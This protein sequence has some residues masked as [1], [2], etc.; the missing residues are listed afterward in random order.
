M[1]DLAFVLVKRAELPTSR[2]VIA[3]GKQLGIALIDAGTS[4]VLAFEIAS[5]GR[6][7]AM[8]AT[9]PHPDAAQMPPA[10]TSPS[11]DEIA[12]ARAHIVV[13]VLGLEGTARVRDTRMAMLASTMIDGGNAV[14]AMLGHGV[15]FRQAK[16]FAQ[17]AALGVD[18]DLP[19]ELAI[20]ITA[21]RE[22]ATRMSFLTH[23]LPRYGREDF[24]VT[25]PIEGE[26]AL[27][28]VLGLVRWMWTDPDKLL[29]TGDTVGRSAT[30]HVRIQRVPSPTGAEA[31]VIRLDLE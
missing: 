1:S 6:L 13:T 12:A 24:Y 10:I 17:M 31:Q 28:F 23:N 20:D 18:G 22:S 11:P 3:R 19:P 8:L 9:V 30:E 15:S 4:D 26:G 16:L 14:G 25:C 29:P 27:D 2:Q 21:A 7:L 5:G